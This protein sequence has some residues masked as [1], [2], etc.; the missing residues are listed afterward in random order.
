MD[1]S[2]LLEEV[3]NPEMTI[4]T[5]PA[6]EIAETDNHTEDGDTPTAS[7]TNQQTNSKDLVEQDEEE[8]NKVNKVKVHVQINQNPPQ[9]GK[10]AKTKQKLRKTNLSTKTK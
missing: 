1:S 6:V 5:H 9:T 4:G 8:E 10:Q 3:H 2:T 7:E